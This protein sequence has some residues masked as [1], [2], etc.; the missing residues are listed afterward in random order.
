MKR[1]KICVQENSVLSSKNYEVLF[2]ANV[3]LHV[4]HCGNR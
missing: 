3:V 4:V 2:I 1:N